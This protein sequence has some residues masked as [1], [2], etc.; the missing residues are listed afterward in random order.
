M[1]DLSRTVTSIDGK[2][3]A[4]RTIKVA[5]NSGGTQY[6]AGIGV[7][8]DNSTGGMQSQVVVVADRFSVMH[9][10]N[11]SPKAVFSVQGGVAFI[12]D[13]MIRNASITTAKIADGAITN[14]KI[15]NAQITAAKIG[16]AEIDTLR[17]KG[18]AV[19][20]LASNAAGDRL[21]YAGVEQPVLSVTFNGS[22]SPCIVN[23]SLD[24]F[25]LL[26]RVYIYRNGSLIAQ[27]IGGNN[28][29]AFAMSVHTATVNVSNTFTVAIHGKKYNAT[30]DDSINYL[31]GRSIGV[32]EAKR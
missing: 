12:N 9:T 4:T 15:A 19:T 8:V 30:G 7:G 21:N 11:G 5:V 22:A 20:T 13:A 10:I 3:Q 6:L 26:N 24:N 14:A 16:T 1:Q 2:I 17:I 25:G 32:F 29:G 18:N 23:V 31:T 27:R 28:W